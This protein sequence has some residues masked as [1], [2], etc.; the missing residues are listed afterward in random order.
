MLPIIIAA[1]I[2][3]V[4]SDEEHKRTLDVYPNIRQ[5]ALEAGGWPDVRFMPGERFNPQLPFRIGDLRT[6][7]RQGIGSTGDNSNINY[8][9]FVVW[10]TPR[11]FLALNPARGTYPGYVRGAQALGW[12]LGPL[13]LYVDQEPA[14]DWDELAE[15]KERALRGEPVPPYAWRVT[16]HEGRGRGASHHQLYPDRLVPVSVFPRGGM[17]ARHLTPSL[18][19]G[20]KIRPD[21][22][23]GT[24]SHTIRQITLDE[25]NRELG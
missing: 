16:G 1:F 20:G 14:L 21:H 17:R 2:G 13:T 19:L 9:G 6:D 3:A 10:M 25:R 8:M 18:L 22:R 4:L 23:G 24:R 5:L 11:D 12:P 7:P 15:H